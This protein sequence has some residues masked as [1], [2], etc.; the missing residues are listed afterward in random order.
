VFVVFYVSWGAIVVWGFGVV[1]MLRFIVLCGVLL[2]FRMF[3]GVFVCF[4]VFC[5]VLFPLLCLGLLWDVLAC[6]GVFYCVLG[7]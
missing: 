6:Y 1:C 3:Q 4:I 5:S 2:G 7:V